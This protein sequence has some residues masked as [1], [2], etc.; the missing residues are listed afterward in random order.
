MELKDKTAI[1]TG[2]G[3]GIGEGI[4]LALAREGANVVLIARRLEGITDVAKRIE[5]KGGKAL[6]FS[7]DVSKMAEIERM[8]EATLKQFGTIDILINNAGIEAPPCQVVDLS[9]EQWERVLSINLKGVFLCCKAVV[10][11][12]I[13]NQSGKIVNIAS[14]AGRRMSFFGSADYTASKYGLVGF[15]HHLAWELAEFKINVNTICPGAVL[16]PLA[17]ESSTPELRA[18]LTKRLIPLGR[19][20]TPEDIAEAVVFLT[21]ERSNWITGQALEVDGGTMTGY[22]EDLRAVVKKRMADMKSAANP[23]WKSGS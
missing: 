18:T 21:S 22:G 6:P 10:P 19:F 9:E 2:A 5:G 23:P 11:T 14:L 1:V 20:G 12:M 13:K 8:V 4:A 16:T 7:A 15:G 3:R 17:E